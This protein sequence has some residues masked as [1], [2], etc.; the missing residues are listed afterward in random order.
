MLVTLMPLNFLSTLFPIKKNKFV[1]DKPRPFSPK[2][3]RALELWSKILL[4]LGKIEPSLATHCCEAYVVRKNGK[5]DRVV[6]DFRPLNSVII[7][8]ELPFTSMRE[9]FDRLCGAKIFT[10]LDMTKAFYS[11]PIKEEDRHKTTFRLNDNCYQFK[12]LPMGLVSSPKAMQRLTNM[13]VKDVE[14]LEGYVDDLVVHSEDFETHV[15]R[16]E[17]L[18]QRLEHY[19]LKVKPSKTKFAMKKIKLL[20][21]LVSEKGLEVPPERIEVIQKI[22]RPR[23]RRQIKSFIGVVNFIREFVEDMSELAKPLYDLANSEH[24]LWTQECEHTF[25]EIKRRITTAPILAIPDE[26]KS[27]VL[28][29]DAS[30]YAVGGVITQKS[31]NGKLNI[32]AYFSK[33]LTNSQKNWSVLKKEFYSIIV[34]L[35][36]YR[37]WLIPSG[38]FYIYTDHKPLIRLNELKKIKSIAVTSFAIELSTYDFELQH[39]PGKDNEL[40]DTLSRLQYSDEHRDEYEGITSGDIMKSIDCEIDNIES[41]ENEIIVKE[42]NISDKD[43]EQIFTVC[44]IPDVCNSDI[45]THQD[46]DSLCKD[47]RRIL[48]D[49]SL[50]S[51]NQYKK[52]FVIIDDI[53]YFKCKRS[54]HKQ[55]NYLK[56]VVPKILIPKIL[57]EYHSNN[58]H[59]G[60]NKTEDI[61]RERYW[62][63]G[64]RDIRDNIVVNAIV[65]ESRLGVKSPSER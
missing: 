44:A 38:K 61:I 4:K 24:W 57:E 37:M 5:E 60:Q 11:V 63:P 55:L 21:L 46:N 28:F 26:S 42:R 25:N 16:V 20:G 3:R 34:A 19:N 9:I 17:K 33:S 50:K 29:C 2:D 35:K 48:S 22:L 8:Y 31:E 51:H 59:L 27:K 13:V 32:I 64:L 1:Q 7:S 47:I 12:F 62:F 14:G 58:G 40:A 18:F 6:I 39:V 56:L 36:R 41:C 49:Q 30:D 23:T 45:K 65:M 15:Q 10:T 54:K 53:I 52:M 43:M